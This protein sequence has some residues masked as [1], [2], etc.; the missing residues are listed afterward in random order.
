MCTGVPYHRPSLRTSLPWSPPLS[1]WLITLTTSSTTAADSLVLRFFLEVAELSLNWS[2]DASS[3]TRLDGLLFDGEVEDLW[4][5]VLSNSSDALEKR[6]G[7]GEVTGVVDALSVFFF[8][9]LFRRV[10]LSASVDLRLESAY[11]S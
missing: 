5:F 11:L 9:V 8:H 2:M 3:G 6:A 7:L 10:C 1:I 4:S